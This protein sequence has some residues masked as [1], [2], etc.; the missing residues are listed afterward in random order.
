[1]AKYWTDILF[2]AGL[3]ALA[4]GLWLI[5]PPLALV[6][7]GLALMGLALAIARQRGRRGTEA[8]N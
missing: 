7:V 6:S 8:N 2:L 3:A 5:Y 1:M 4:T